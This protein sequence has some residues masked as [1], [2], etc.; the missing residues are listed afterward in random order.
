MLTGRTD[1]LEVL[2]RLSV[3]AKNTGRQ[4][5][6]IEKGKEYTAVAAERLSA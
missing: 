4:Y 6:G 1:L 5:I 2:Q 3:S